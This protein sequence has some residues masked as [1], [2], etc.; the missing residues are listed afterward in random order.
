[1]TGSFVFINQNKQQPEKTTWAYKRTLTRG[2]LHVLPHCFIVL[3]SLQ[4]AC[5]E[6]PS[7]DQSR[8]DESRSDLLHFWPAVKPSYGT[9]NHQLGKCN[10][11]VQIH[12]NKWCVVGLIRKQKLLVEISKNKQWPQV[13]PLEKATAD[14]KTNIA[15]VKMKHF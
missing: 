6:E 1:M 8:P 9:L 2:S 10:G 15:D 14:R 13:K 11:L 7:L 12:K 5:H 3:T 4:F